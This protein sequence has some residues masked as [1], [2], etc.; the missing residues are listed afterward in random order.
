ML[1][2]LLLRNFSSLLLL[3]TPVFHQHFTDFPGFISV[4]SFDFPVNMLYL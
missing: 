1:Q 3:I 4:F 2:L